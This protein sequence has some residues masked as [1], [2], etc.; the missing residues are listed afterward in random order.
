MA[1]L[2]ILHLEGGDADVSGLRLLFDVA[3]LLHTLSLQYVYFVSPRN[4]VELAES[5]ASDNLLELDL[6]DARL[7][8]DAIAA[9]GQAK[10]LRN[11]LVLRVGGRHWGNA[12]V[13]SIAA[14]PLGQRLMLLDRGPS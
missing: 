14:S 13:A 3:P 8:A 2:R 12:E 9:L 11:L 4:I 10:H 5:P 1:S 7:D 6:T